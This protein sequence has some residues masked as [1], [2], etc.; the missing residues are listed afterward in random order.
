MP[1]VSCLVFDFRSDCCQLTIV[2][3]F[4]NEVLSSAISIVVVDRN[5]RPVDG[6]L[7]EVGPAVPVQ[8]CV[9]VRKDAALEQWIL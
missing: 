1:L 2:D 7:L 8:L 6:N 9:E 5:T 4:M 3:V